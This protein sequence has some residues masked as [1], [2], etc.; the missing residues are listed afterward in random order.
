MQIQYLLR[1]EHISSDEVSFYN[2]LLSTFITVTREN[3]GEEEIGYSQEQEA[4]VEAALFHRHGPTTFHFS[5]A[6]DDVSDVMQMADTHFQLERN[7][8]EKYSDSTWSAHERDAMTWEGQKAI[9]VGRCNG[10]VVSIACL[11]L[12]FISDNQ[13]SKTKYFSVG[14]GPFFVPPL[15][16]GRAHIIDA[17][18]AAGYFCSVLL[19]AL[20]LQLPRYG[21]LGVSIYQDYPDDADSQEVHPYVQQIHDKLE[22]M[23]EL[24]ASGYFLQADSKHPTITFLPVTLER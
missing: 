3:R 24:L 15:L 13:A 1:R 9:L 19:Q 14:V 20:Y 12:R 2:G 16:R 7:L 10:S 21:S 4:R 17:S 22:I 23:R 6:G 11:D 18:I 8:K 5:P